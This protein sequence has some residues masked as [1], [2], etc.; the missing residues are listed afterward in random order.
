MPDPPPVAPPEQAD[1]APAATEPDAVVT[2]P[3][4]D[5]VVTAPA[6]QPVAP[7]S[8]INVSIRILSPGDNGSVDQDGGDAQSPDGA[9]G[10]A[11]VIVGGADVPA[12]TTWTWNWTWVTDDGC[13][14]AAGAPAVPVPTGSEWTWNWTWQCGELAVGETLPIP[15]PVM[16][17]VGDL[18]EVAVAWAPA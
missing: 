16:D 12:P 6:T 10:S 14:P 8:N 13:D 7:P 9:A 5:P 11:D 15:A 2:E 18:S 3:P 4:P 1:G 17:A